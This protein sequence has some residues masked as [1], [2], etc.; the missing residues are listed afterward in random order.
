MYEPKIDGL[1]AKRE[2]SR[3]KRDIDKM[4]KKLRGNLSVINGVLWT[5]I[6]LDEKRK[7]RKE[8]VK[9]SHFKAR[10]KRDEQMKKDE[11]RRNRT[12]RI[13]GQLANQEGEA[14]S[15]KKK[16]YNLFPDM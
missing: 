15:F 2:V 10:L 5:I 14:K 12:K 13:I 16:K 11:D 3:Q 6:F 7:A 1:G 4:T 9:D 8:T